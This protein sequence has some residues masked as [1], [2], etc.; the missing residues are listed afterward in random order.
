MGVDRVAKAKADGYTVVDRWNVA[1]RKAVS[2]PDIRARW[3]AAGAEANAATPD[4]FASFWKAD[5][6]RW[7]RIADATRIEAE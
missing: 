1:M 6:A 3:E 2:D 5:R 4:E 7:Q